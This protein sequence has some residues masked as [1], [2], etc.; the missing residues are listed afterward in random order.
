MRLVTKWAIFKQ[1]RLGSE[2]KDLS[3]G[4]G[5]TRRPLRGA[6]G[7]SDRTWNRGDRGT[8][9]KSEEG[10]FLIDFNFSVT[11]DTQQYF[12][13]VSGV[14]YSGEAITY[15][16]KCPPPQYC[17]CPPGPK[18]S[19]SNVIGSVPCVNFPCWLLCTEKAQ[20]L[21]QAQRHKNHVGEYKFLYQSRINTYAQSEVN[22]G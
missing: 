15:F 8:A 4:G 20:V 14:Q 18:H 21:F 19:D 12:L 22:W 1:S 16:T 10:K 7:G 9:G 3:V 2:H 13:F 6:P 5:S 17:Q 11:V